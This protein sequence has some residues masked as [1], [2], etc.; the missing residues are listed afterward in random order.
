MEKQDRIVYLDGLVPSIFFP[1]GSKKRGGTCDFSTRKCRRNCPSYLKTN[2]LEKYTFNFF[3]TEPSKIIAERITKELEDNYGINL[4]QWFSWGD[5]PVDKTVK[6]TK[7]M[8]ILSKNKIIQCG[9][10]RNKK[11][12]DKALSIENINLGL[13]MEQEEYDELIIDRINRYKIANG[14]VGVPHYDTGKVELFWGFDKRY[15]GGCS[16][17]WY[18]SPNG[19]TREADCAK[20]YKERVGCF[21]KWDGDDIE[22]KK[23]K[24]RFELIDL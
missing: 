13:T 11:L 7:I 3:A 17:G 9:F 16:G 8:R 10:T 22:V 5:C 1:A 19:V 12:W 4:L 6:I 14:L 15:R 20:C 21:V 18:T 23:V 2:K 24:S